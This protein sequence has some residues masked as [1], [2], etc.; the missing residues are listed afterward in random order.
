MFPFVPSG[1]S[2]Q[3][4]L[5]SAGPIL[6]G[7]IVAYPGTGDLRALVAHRVVRVEQ[8]AGA[9][10]YVTRGDAQHHEEVIPECAI[11]YV[12]TRVNHR[13][14]TYATNGT[15]GR[16]LARIALQH[17]IALRLAT[18]FARV[19]V[20]LRQRARSASANTGNR[21][22]LGDRPG[23]AA[24][25]LRQVPVAYDSTPHHFEL[26]SISSRPSL[27]PPGEL[28]PRDSLLRGL[29][30]ELRTP[31]NAILGFAEVLLGELDGPLDDDERE[32][33]SVVRE[34]GQKLLVLINEV[35]DLAAALVAQR[36]P[37][38]EDC[39]AV[40]LLEDVRA[41]LE[42]RRGVRPVHVRVGGALDRLD[43]W[44][45]RRALSRVLRALG[46][47]ALCATSAGEISL[48]ASLVGDDLRVRVHG[49]GLLL[50]AD[51]LTS[52]AA[53]AASV[54]GDRDKRLFGLRLLIARKLAER[55]PGTLA[56]ESNALGGASLVLVMPSRLKRGGS[57]AN[58]GASV[59]DVSVA[60]GY[61]AAM[62]HD[63]RTPLNA[64]LGFAD[65]LTL[66]SQSP[67][68][69]PQ[70]KSLEIIRERARD[71][72][73]L[74][75]DMIDWAKLEAGEL[76]LHWMEQPVLSLIERVVETATQ[77]SGA[78]GLCVDLDLAPDLGSVRVDDVRF[79]QALV[80]LLDHAVRSNPAPRV[81]L[82][83]RRVDGAEPGK[84]RLR[85]EIIDPSLLVREQDHAA[86]F[87]AFRPSHAPTGQRIAG[88]QL[89]TSV[90][91]ALLRAHGGDVWFESRPGRGTTF[92]AEL[93]IGTS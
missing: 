70:R 3:V 15:V 87:A 16:V 28:D 25:G 24:A 45:D 1:C 8:V 43:V 57:A 49:D 18:T 20:E 38:G 17:G 56:A 26:S 4:R 48:E 69:E 63:L 42:E 12:V 13:A 7:D 39:D 6:R 83:A 68:S 37:V 5:A 53:G 31:L 75:D 61:L 2:L 73:A 47:L 46:E 77:R 34:A 90:A 33:V 40:A 32:N 92:V 72:T 59:E 58:S 88:L 29:K 36:E 30:H 52:M 78:R 54:A 22:T 14:F 85:I 71:L 79:V 76:S 67:W 91:R 62:G 93:P 86:L 64:I 81:K 74:V 11:A 60:I 35:L 50:P 55:L 51:A 82:S 10:W 9:T 80:G 89:G 27:A 84:S 19:A 41:A 65:L 23:Q 44:V 66:R 21:H